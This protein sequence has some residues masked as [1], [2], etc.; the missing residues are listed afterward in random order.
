M[1]IKFSYTYNFVMLKY[2]FII[3]RAFLFH[4]S[5]S[6]LIQ[7]PLTGGKIFYCPLIPSHNSILKRNFNSSMITHVQRKILISIFFHAF[8]I[9]S[10]KFKI[11]FTRLLII[12]SHPS[13][14]VYK[15]VKIYI[16]FFIINSN[17]FRNFITYKRPLFGD[18]GIFIIIF[19]VL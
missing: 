17:S 7:F 16:F 1:G 4:I 18:Q 2:I 13:R 12:L 10:F 11:L 3:I 15:L 9:I 8:K 19:F 14:I 6:N 5:S